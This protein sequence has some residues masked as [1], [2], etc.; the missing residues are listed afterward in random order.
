VAVGFILACER[1][2]VEPGRAAGVGLVRLRG[3]RAGIH[4][5]FTR[6][7]DA[8]FELCDAMAC[9]PGPVPC[10]VELSLEPEF[11]RGHAMVYDALANGRVDAGRL[12]RVL[13]EGLAPARAGEPLMFGVDVTP[14]PRPDCRYV[15]GL[16]MVQVRGAGGDRLVSGW[17]VSVLVG[18]CWGASSWVDPLDMRRIGPGGGSSRAALGQIEGLLEDLSATGRWRAGQAV[19]L[20]M[21]DAGYPVVWLAHALAGRP[22]QV[23]GRVRGDR[24]FY[25]PAPAPGGTPGRSARHGHRFVCADSTTHPEPDATITARAER[26]GRVRVSAWWNLHQAVARSGVWSGFPAGRQLPVLP[27]TLIKI[28]VERL[29][30]GAQPKPLWLWHSTP[31]AGTAQVELLWRAYLRR[32]DQEHFH[33]FAKV[34]LALAR[35]RLISADAADRWHAVVLAAYAQL[36]AAAP[37][38]ADQPRAW[39]RKTAPG[40][41][42]TPCRVRAG[43]RRLRGQLGTPAGAVKPVRP[44]TGRPKGRKNP[45]KPRVPVYNKSDIT[46][47]ASLARAAT[48]P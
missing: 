4:G 41:L 9:A 10:P 14:I 22:V 43:F 31:A 29:P 5:C 26:Y 46:L 11:R 25:G 20:V 34:H 18:L 21:L 19:P 37:L 47:M 33:R 35:A 42:P 2:S 13:V 1:G 32:F 23:L 28:S 8:L 16:S 38:V 27:G 24:V 7:A 30:R 17:P 15:Q 45:P 6:R 48:P 3:L 12:R 44:G 39:Q 40:A 36:R